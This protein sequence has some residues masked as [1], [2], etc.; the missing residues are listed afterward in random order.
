M[1]VAKVLA[2]LQGQNDTTQWHSLQWARGA[3]LPGLGATTLNNR[4]F[5]R[6]ATGACP[7]PP[8]VRQRLAMLGARS[9][10]V[11]S[12]PV[13][14]WQMPTCRAGSRARL[15]GWAGSSNS[16]SCEASTARASSR[17]PRVALVLPACG[18]SQG[19]NLGALSSQ[20]ARPPTWGDP[21]ATSQ[22]AGAA[23]RSRCHSVA[24]C[25]NIA[26]FGCLD[27][28]DA[29]LPPLAHCVGDAGGGIGGLPATV[30][31][32]HAAVYRR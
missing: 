22:A 31:V 9:W 10:W 25:V 20:V 12:T 21:V 18:A 6:G 15:E 4:Q 26:S 7:S 16:G 1:A 24:Y 17:P 11:A 23:M 28:A 13:S 19:V 5:Q 27:S 2:R 32:D 3:L 8:H 29:K 14:M 30:S